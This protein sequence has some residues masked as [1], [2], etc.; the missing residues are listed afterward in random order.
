M[1]QNPHPGPLPFEERGESL[2]DELNRNAER[3]SQ[4]DL[5]DREQACDRRTRPGVFS[6]RSWREH[7]S[8]RFFEKSDHLLARDSWKTFKEIFNR[9]AAFEII[10]QILD[11]HAACRRNKARHS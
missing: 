7:A 1:L 2:S 4:N 10:D 3:Y 6:L 5:Q 8:L 11:R 9:I